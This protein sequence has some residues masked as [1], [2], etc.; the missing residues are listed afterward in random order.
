MS[1]SATAG[2]LATVLNNVQVPISADGSGLARG[3]SAQYVKFNTAVKYIS[4]GVKGAQDTDAP[5]VVMPLLE[6]G[7]EGMVRITLPVGETCVELPVPTKFVLVQINL[8]DTISG[9]SGHT[10]LTLK[11]LG[12]AAV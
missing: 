1:F 9:S 10:P 5:N 12:Q 4:L 2:T 11:V 7:V 3:S 8:A 6:D